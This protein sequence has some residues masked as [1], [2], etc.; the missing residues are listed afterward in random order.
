RETVQ[1]A[2]RRAAQVSGRTDLGSVQSRKTIAEPGRRAAGLRVE[3]DL[4]GRNAHLRAY[5]RNGIRHLERAA[6]DFGR[7]QDRAAGE[8]V[9]EINQLPQRHR[10]TETG[11]QGEGETGR[12][13]RESLVSLSPCLLVPLSPC[14]LLLISVFLW[15]ILLVF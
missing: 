2:L 11:R 5:R 10:A 15:P 6:K 9:M 12:Q 4:A 7:R 13:G 8:G 3:T 14:L 1:S